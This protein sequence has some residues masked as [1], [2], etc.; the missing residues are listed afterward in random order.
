LEE[1]IDNVELPPRL[2]DNPILA[3]PMVAPIPIPVDKLIEQLKMLP[4]RHYES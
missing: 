2:Q 4:R 1:E 3:I